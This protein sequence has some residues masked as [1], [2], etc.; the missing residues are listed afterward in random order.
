MAELR[1]YKAIN[2]DLDTQSL[3][4]R[5][6][7]KGRA[8]AYSAVRSFM[9]QHGFEHRQG[10]GYRSTNTLS[11]LDIADLM[12]A[13]YKQLEW[14]SACVQKLDVTNIGREYDLNAIAKRRIEDEKN[15]TRTVT[16]DVEL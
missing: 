5:F 3:R 11:D 15:I 12:V 10:S 6:G 9:K 8:K 4:E 2:F 1:R 13:M 7:E 16:F 14:L